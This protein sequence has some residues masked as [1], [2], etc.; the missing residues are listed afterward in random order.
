MM[1]DRKSVEEHLSEIQK[2]S[3]P[4]NQ[5]QMACMVCLKPKTML[6]LAYASHKLR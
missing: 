2:G 1:N 3:T 4:Y 6:N 5:S